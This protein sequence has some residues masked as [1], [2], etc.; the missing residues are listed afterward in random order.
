MRVHE[1]ITKRRNELGISVRDAARGIGVSL[2]EYNDIEGHADEISTVTH[3]SEVKQLC[4]LL[5]CEFLDLFGMRCDFCTKSLRSDEELLLPRNELIR[6]RRELRGLSAFELADRLGCSEV[7]VEEMEGD[8]DFLESWSIDLIR[9]LAREIR[10][11]LQILL[12]VRCK[13]CD[14]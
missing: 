6:R 8:E 5:K 4:A 13:K 7:A 1:K 12:K 10:V 3:L 11:P 9:N 14:R 2:E